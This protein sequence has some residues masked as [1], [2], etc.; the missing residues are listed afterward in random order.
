MEGRADPSLYPSRISESPMS[1]TPPSVAQCP[2]RPSGR[3]DRHP[4]RLIRVVLSESI[5]PSH[6]TS[7]A[8]ERR[9]RL[10]A[11]RGLGSSEA[12]LPSRSIR[13]DTSVSLYP[14]RSIRVAP[15][16]SLQPSLCIRVAPSE[17]LHPSRPP[18][19]EHRRRLGALHRA[20]PH[21]RRLLLAPCSLV[22][23]TD[24][25]VSLC[26]FACFP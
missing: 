20:A 12:T 24:S 18:A 22:S 17:S 8:D 15:S 14:S 11:L 7:D 4:S 23:L 3:P 5:Y 2:S 25:L 6:F 9:R 1:R 26:L 21:R 13:V 10:G 16:E 19:D